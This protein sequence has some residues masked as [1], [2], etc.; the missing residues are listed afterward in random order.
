MSSLSLSPWMTAGA[1]TAI[2]LVGDVSL[3][4][5]NLAVG[6][7]AYNLLAYT[8]YLNYPTMEMGRVNSYWNALNNVVTAAAG[9]LLFDEAYGV[10]EWVG[11]IFIS[12]G[13]YLITPT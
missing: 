11:F 6:I 2:E 13:V 12:L 7:P 1:L 8:I 4:R 10:R 5:Q 3:K 9:A